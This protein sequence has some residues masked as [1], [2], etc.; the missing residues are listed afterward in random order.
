M[1]KHAVSLPTYGSFA[2]NAPFLLEILLEI[3]R[4]ISHSESVNIEVK[5]WKGTIYAE[6]AFVL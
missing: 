1:Q 2:A 5:I 3:S 6:F 4:K